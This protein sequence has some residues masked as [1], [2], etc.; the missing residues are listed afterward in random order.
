MEKNAALTTAAPAIIT[1][2]TTPSCEPV[3][4]PIIGNAT[5]ASLP[6][7]TAPSESS[8]LSKRLPNPNKFSGDK[9]DLRRFVTQIEQKMNVNADRF[10]T[11]TTRLAYVQNRLTGI[12]YDQVSPY[13][14]STTMQP[15]NYPKI[16]AILKRAYGDPNCVQNARNKLF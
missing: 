15:T 6:I 7:A 4:K 16:L 9:N 12:A 1:P 14:R 8:R 2:Y 5:G 3:A 10:S 11:P 13:M